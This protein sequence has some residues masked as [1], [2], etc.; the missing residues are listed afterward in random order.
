MFQS[1]SLKPAVLSKTNN[2]GHST[3]IKVAAI[4][5]KANALRQ[6]GLYNRQVDSEQF[7]SFVLLPTNHASSLEQ[8]MVGSDEEDG[9]DGWSDC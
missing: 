1:F 9:G 3:N 2:K 7:L 5:E 4:L 6:V 8:A